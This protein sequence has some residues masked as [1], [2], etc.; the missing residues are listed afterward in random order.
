MNVMFVSPFFVSM[1][2]YHTVLV[3]VLLFAL[4]VFLHVLGHLCNLILL[5]EM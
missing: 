2:R 4:C 3:R 1:F 5:L